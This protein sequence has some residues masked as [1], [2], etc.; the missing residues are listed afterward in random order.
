MRF[1]KVIT[2]FAALTL[3]CGVV[4]AQLSGAI[5]VDAG[6]ETTQFGDMLSNTDGYYA[7]RNTAVFGITPVLTLGGR[8]DRNQGWSVS[9][10]GDAR[11]PSDMSNATGNP[12]EYAGDLSLDWRMKFMGLGGGFETREFRLPSDPTFARPNL[13]LVGV[14]FHYKVTFGPHSAAYAQLAATVWA[15]NVNQNSSSSNASTIKLASDIGVPYDLK[16]TAGYVFGS[17]HIA[18]KGT[19]IHRALYFNVNGLQS[20]GMDFHQNEFTAGLV[21][22]F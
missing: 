17:K 7:K 22:T 9:L 20:T 6:Y 10:G 1:A 19:Y 14:P 11:I 13:L 16:A 18:L 21:R 3:T 2:L 8:N 4:N 15:Y 12:T 5:G